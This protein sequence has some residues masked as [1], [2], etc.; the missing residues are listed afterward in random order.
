MLGLAVLQIGLVAAGL[1]AW[2][3]PILAATGVPCPGCGLTH[4]C[5]ALLGG[6]WRT[7]L[8]TNPVAPAV[9]LGVGL[10]LA[11]ATLPAALHPAL[12]NAVARIE[13]TTRITW[14]ALGVMVIAWIA[15]LV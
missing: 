15:R 6:D 1:P 12:V 5:V 13:R 7:A 11:S 14:I 3:C 8:T 9:V 10:V 4:A 2:P